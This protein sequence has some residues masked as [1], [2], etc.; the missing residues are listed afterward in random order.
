MQCAYLAVQI[1]DRPVVRICE[2]NFNATLGG[3]PYRIAQT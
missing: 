2:E 1:A 3:G